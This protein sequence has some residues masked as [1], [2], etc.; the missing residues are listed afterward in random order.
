MDLSGTPETAAEWMARLRSDRATEEDRAAYVRW[1]DASPENRAAADSLDE[2]WTMAGS[3]E[4]DPMVQELLSPRRPRNGRGRVW[5]P[6]LAVVVV[7][8]CLSLAAWWTGRRMLAGASYETASGEQRVVDLADGSRLHLN[9]TTRLEVA[10]RSDVRDVRLVRGQAFFEVVADPERPFVV[11]AGDKEITVL[12]TKFDVLL[13]GGETR[14]TVIEG[15]VAVTSR[16]PT[17][18]S[19]PG[20][21]SLLAAKAGEAAPVPGAGPRQ[22]THPTHRIELRASDAITWPESAP[23]SQLTS[24]TA[25]ASV[26]AWLDGKVIFDATPLRDAIA[27]IDRY[28][29]VR[30]RLAS[31]ELGAMTVSG[32]FYVDRLAEVDSLIFALENSLPIVVER[33]ESE[34]LLVASG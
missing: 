14:V 29:P 7:V 26:E 34:L 15:R 20:D 4:Q 33:R 17:A 18:T 6:R 19:A 27:E 5:A 22:A 31:P 8:L 30:V 12:G 25:M 9:V 23:P 2:V 13:E 3:L 28:T 11:T 10:L 24:K 1:L 32:V 21:P 16:G